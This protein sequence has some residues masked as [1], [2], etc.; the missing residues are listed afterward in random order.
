[1]HIHRPS[2]T[3]DAGMYRYHPAHITYTYMDYLAH[4]TQMCMKSILHISGIH[5]QTRPSCAHYTD[6]CR[7]HLAH[8]KYLAHITYT[9]TLLHASNRH[10]W[11]LP[12]IPIIDIHE[13]I[14]GARRRSALA[15][16]C[17]A[18]T[19]PDQSCGGKYGVCKRGVLLGLVYIGEYKILPYRSPPC[20]SIFFGLIKKTMGWWGSTQMKGV[21]N[22]LAN[23]IAI[24]SICL[25]NWKEIEKNRN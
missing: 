2:C 12:N 25:T 3:H 9:Y 10:V 16:S 6:T 13:K 8:L 7:E 14:R 1:M 19:G 11:R 5:T 17:R 21:K 22:V 23:K 4:M 20:I 15:R 24:F 18:P